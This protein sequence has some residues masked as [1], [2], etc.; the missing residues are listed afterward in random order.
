[1]EKEILGIASVVFACIAFIPYAYQ[2]LKKQVKPHVFTWI[3][4]GVLTGI[5]FFAQGSDGAGAGSW[6]MG[7]TSFLVIS[8]TVLSLFYGE[9][10]ITRSDW[11]SFVLA[12]S[13]I[14][15]WMIT[16]SAALSIII[17]LIVDFLGFYPTVRKSYQKPHEEMAWMFATN[18][19]KHIFILAALGNWSFITAAYSIVLLL[20]NAGFALLLIVRRWQLR[21]K[22]D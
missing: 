12:L 13:A 19:F 10:N 8:I 6:G 17:V 11:I 15:V 1:M 20:Q 7:A 2:I 9:K 16:N 5:A 21:E 18:S 3:V 22:N 4:W 14:P